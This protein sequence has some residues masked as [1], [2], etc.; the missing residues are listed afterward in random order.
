MVYTKKNLIQITY[1]MIYDIGFK[2]ITIRKISKKAN[3]SIAALYRHFENFDHLLTYACIGFLEPYTEDYKFIKTYTN[4]PVEISIEMWLHLSKTSF[5]KPEI[6]AQLFLGPYKNEIYNIIKDYYIIFDR[7]TFNVGEVSALM[8]DTGDIFFRNYDYIKN[9]LPDKSKG[10]IQ[11]L[12]DLT[13]FTYC[14]ILG[15][16]LKNTYTVAEVEKMSERFVDSLQYLYEN[17]LVNYTERIY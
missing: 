14:G 4:D 5:F 12:S 16:L 6:F 15:T 7:D 3:C 13:V 10:E 2:N 11:I 1:D 17:E 8:E 9:S